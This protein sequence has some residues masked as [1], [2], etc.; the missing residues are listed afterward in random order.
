ML[1]PAGCPW[2]EKLA[3]KLNVCKT[4]LGLSG[5]LEYKKD[6]SDFKSDSWHDNFT[7]GVCNLMPNLQI[8]KIE[9]HWNKWVQYLKVLLSQDL[10]LK[11]FIAYFY[12]FSYEIRG[13]RIFF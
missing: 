9:D 3:V 4:F 5:N 7:A 8:K 10:K 2:K 11:C 6:E 13:S 12:L 1:L